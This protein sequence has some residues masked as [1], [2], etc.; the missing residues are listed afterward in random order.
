MQPWQESLLMALVIGIVGGVFTV[1]ESAKREA[2]YGGIVA[3]IFHYLGAVCF[4]A[5][6]PGILIAIIRR[7]GFGVAFPI[8]I[9]LMAV[10]F[11]MLLG[12]AIFE[13]PARA[14]HAPTE[15]VWTEEKARSSGL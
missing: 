14:Q 5:V 13:Q 15:D 7:E 6:V 10:A 12:F 1:R 2:I 9:G 11:L 8:G 4:C 3:Q